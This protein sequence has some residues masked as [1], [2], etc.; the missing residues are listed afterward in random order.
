MFISI[1][2][3]VAVIVGLLFWRTWQAPSSTP[4]SKA[5]QEKIAPPGS[6]VPPEAGRARDEWKRTHPEGQAGG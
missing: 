3:V 6:G 1:I 2:A 4:V 5:E